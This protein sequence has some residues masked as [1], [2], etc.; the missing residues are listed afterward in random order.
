[1]ENLTTA[2][3]VKMVRDLKINEMREE[4]A[5]LRQ[6]MEIARGRPDYAKHIRY[7]ERRLAE[8]VAEYMK[9]ME[10]GK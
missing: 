3:I 2:E 8:T 4:I 6:A 1:M 9:V 10:R 7:L 5:Q